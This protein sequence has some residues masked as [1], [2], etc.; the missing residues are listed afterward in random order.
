[1][2]FSPKILLYK[3]RRLIKV[4]IFKGKF[5]R[6]YKATDFKTVD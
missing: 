6:I 1:M 3:C 2:V 5:A 4:Y